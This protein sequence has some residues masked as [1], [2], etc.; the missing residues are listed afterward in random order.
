MLPLTLTEILCLS[1]SC[2]GGSAV[3]SK[4]D[5]ER[6]EGRKGG[7]V[8]GRFISSFI[9][10]RIVAIGLSVVGLQFIRTEQHVACNCRYLLP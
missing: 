10:A 2:S 1:G 9:M 6:S 4:S 7:G 5:S 3:P 8:V